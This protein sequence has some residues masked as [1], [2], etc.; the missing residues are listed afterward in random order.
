MMIKVNLLEDKTLS[1][2]IKLMSVFVLLF[3]IGFILDPQGSQLNVFFIKTKD[4]FADFFNVLHY[5][6]ERNPYFNERNGFDQKVYLP[7]SY[8]LLY[9][10]TL[11]SDYKNLSL[12]EASFSNVGLVSVFVF[13]LLSVW[14]LFYS[15]NKMWVNQKLSVKVWVF[16]LLFFSY[17][18]LFS[19]ERGNLIV[20]VV[21]CIVFFLNYYNSNNKNLRY[22]ALVLLCLASIIKIYPVLL[23]LLLVKDKRY[24]DILF[25]VVTS[26]ILTILPVFF[27]ENG[28][29]N[30]AKLLSNVQL[31]SNSYG[32]DA[33]YPR[34]SLPH[35]AFV[36]SK[37]LK[38]NNGITL[39]LIFISKIIVVLCSLISIIL[40]F[41]QKNEWKR[42]ALL[43][44]VIIQFPTNSALYC[45]L[46]FF[47][48]IILY[49]SRKEFRNFD[50][51]Y[52]VL[53]CI[54][55]NP[56]QIVVMNYSLTYIISNFALW[57]IWI[58]LIIDSLL[59]FRN[60]KLK[61]NDSVNL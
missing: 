13:S 23:G 4:F 56:V 5:I 7:L 27:F 22:L 33:V 9:P 19:I 41:F 17:I 18:N 3:M 54:F 43:V 38:L 50:W 12:T 26:L 15:L 34:F 40:M 20:I 24:K 51:L 21:G 42:I 11:F 36:F 8:L 29:A 59:C 37:V 48:V 2:F 45:G 61:L 46:Y 30:F 32:P 14:L 57:G 52:S 1:L 60:V 35:I 25:C 44:L 28:L 58:V 55:L 47:P 6:S 31:N 16:I 49:F 10:F 53:F 39:G